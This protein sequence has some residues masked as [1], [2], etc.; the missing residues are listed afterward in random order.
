[1]LGA[2]DD[3]LTGLHRAWGNCAFPCEDLT[4][5]G[6]GVSGVFVATYFKAAVL[7]AR[8]RR[9]EPPP[10]PNLLSREHVSSDGLR[11]CAFGVPRHPG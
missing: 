4:R 10:S 9:C 7:A 2:S 6:A 11:N 1:M 8:L 3:P 5:T